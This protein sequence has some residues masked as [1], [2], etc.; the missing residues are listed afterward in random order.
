MAR[1]C[2]CCDHKKVKEINRDLARGRSIRSISRRYNVTE[3]S[4]TRHRDGH[5]TRQLRAGAELSLKKQG[6]DV[7]EEL[8]QLME[9]TK[10]IFE[11]AEQDGH[12]R[13][14]LSAIQQIRG[15]LTLVAQIQAEIYKQ[16]L[17]EA[18]TP[19]PTHDPD[20]E[21]DLS[22][23]SQEERDVYFL[24]SQKLLQ[25]DPKMTIEGIIYTNGAYTHSTP[26]VTQYTSDPEYAEYTP[27]TSRQTGDNGSGRM[28][29]TRR[30]GD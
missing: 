3:G 25:G 12:K 14:A 29:R 7:M 17:T 18:Q 26:K 6:L 16:K 20:P 19:F 24:L 11:Q 8:S 9:K 15:N 2:L 21:T 13:L 23:L 5:L 10:Q 28:I 30:P 22:I 1:A 4:I 27:R